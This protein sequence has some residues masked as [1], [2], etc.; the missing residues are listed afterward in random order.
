M[1]ANYLAL[2]WQFNF[3]QLLLNLVIK[4]VGKTC[5]HSVLSAA[6][7]KGRQY[8]PYEMRHNYVELQL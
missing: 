3:W 8:F 5:A 6:H 7:I 2:I 1:Y 4:F